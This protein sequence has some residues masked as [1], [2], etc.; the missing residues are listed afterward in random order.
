MVIARNEIDYHFPVTYPEGL[1]LYTRIARIGDTSFTFEGLLEVE[2]DT[3]LVATN[4]SV[5]VWLDSASGKPVRVPDDFR[6]IVRSY[7]T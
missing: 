7:E 2:R 1:V 4:I 5:H 6:E 3:R